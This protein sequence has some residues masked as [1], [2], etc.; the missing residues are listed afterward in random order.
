MAG[1]AERA[2]G[3]ARTSREVAGRSRS[4]V[5]QAAGIVALLGGAS[6]A[7]VRLVRN[8]PIDAA[9][10]AGP[11]AFELATTL[12]IVAPALAAV[13]MGVAA[14]T[15]REWVA[16]VVAGTFTLLTAVTGAVSV[17]AA[18]VVLAAGVLALVPWAD[19]T[20]GPTIVAGGFVVA[21]A[22]SLG[23]GMGVLHASARTFGTVVT[24]GA[25]AATPLVVRP[26][27]GSLLVGAAAAL[28]VVAV[29][30]SAPFVT[31]ASVLVVGAAIDPPLVLLAAGVGGAVATV[32]SGVSTGRTAVAVGG[33]LL[34]AAGVP[35]TV[36]RALAVV[37][38]ASLVLDAVDSRTT[39]GDADAM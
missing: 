9:V 17:P 12:A 8:A 27:L 23:G 25:L 35:A 4:E 37:L 10:L 6:I 18:G 39:G 36:P 2:R 3:H 33:A 31:S 5:R 34:L 32:A 14:P 38:G 15:D 24:L 29:T 22:L 7:L 11:T 30:L 16:L 21:L 20:P 13:A 26:S 1:N 19:L 28:G